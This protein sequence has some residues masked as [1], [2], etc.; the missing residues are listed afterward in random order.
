MTT[1]LEDSTNPQKRISELELQVAGMKARLAAFEE[2]FD[3]K[4]KLPKHI[5]DFED[6]IVVFEDKMGR[7]YIGFFDIGN[8][9]WWHGASWLQ[10]KEE[11]SMPSTAYSSLLL[12]DAIKR[13]YPLPG[14]K[15]E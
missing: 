3:P 4:E 6:E 12:T 10:T 15:V 13:W 8:R 9:T 14:R 5:S 2:G 7:F 1:D 11:S